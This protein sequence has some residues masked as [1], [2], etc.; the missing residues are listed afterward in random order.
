LVALAVIAALPAPSTGKS[1]AQTRAV[2]VPT[3]TVVGCEQPASHCM[4][5]A[6]L[7]TNVVR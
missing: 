7:P 1:Q 3:R 2:S 6:K 4:V 5:A